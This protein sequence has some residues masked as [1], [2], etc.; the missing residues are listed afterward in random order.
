MSKS[1]DAPVLTQPASGAHYDV[2][3]VGAGPYG[4]STAAHLMGQG[5]KVAIF[6][7]PMELWNTYMP[8]G[9]LLRSYWW[10]TNLSDPGNQYGLERYLREVEGVPPFD[11]LATSGHESA[12]FPGYIA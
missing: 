6:G 2:V 8:K 1:M 3:V 12:R 5:L 9:M 10:A 7:K 4:L 11:K